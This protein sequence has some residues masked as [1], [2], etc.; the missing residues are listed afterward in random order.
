[1]SNEL[2]V[3]LKGAQEDLEILFAQ[4]EQAHD[5][6]GYIDNIDFIRIDSNLDNVSAAIKTM[7]KAVLDLEGKNGSN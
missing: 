5:R 7:K 4:L 2:I 3:E 6:T 1:M